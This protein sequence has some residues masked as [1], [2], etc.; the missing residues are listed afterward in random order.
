MTTN[1]QKE[2][3]MNK[4]YTLLIKHE[5]NNKWSPEFGDNDKEVVEFELGAWLYDGVKKKDTKIICTDDTQKAIDTYV[6]KLNKR[7]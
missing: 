3:K 2:N 7:I 4:Y 5:I 6:N 1:K